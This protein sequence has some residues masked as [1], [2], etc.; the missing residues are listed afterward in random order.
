MTQQ[1]T[2]TINIVLGDW[3]TMKR[4]VITLARQD[5]EPDLCYNQVGGMWGM[6]YDS[7]YPE[8]YRQFER[9]GDDLNELDEHLIE[10]RKKFKLFGKQFIV[11]KYGDKIIGYCLWTYSFQTD[12][13]GCYLEYI[14]VDKDFRKRGIGEALMRTF[15]KWAEMNDRMYKKV[16]FDATN[17]ELVRFYSK[18]GFEKEGGSISITEKL[19][20]WCSTK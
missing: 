20:D 5:D 19:D 16:T 3:D 18:L 6:F 10:R 1:Q 4:E 15:I 9:D 12:G 7:V 14:L 17:P 11:A 8:L 13:G 2:T